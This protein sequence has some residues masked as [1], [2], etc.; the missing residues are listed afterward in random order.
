MN[1]LPRGRHVETIAPKSDT[2]TYGHLMKCPECGLWFDCR[3]LAAALAHNGPMPHP[4][5][6]KPQ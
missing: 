5:N 1:D 4:T 2:P 3:D 6:N